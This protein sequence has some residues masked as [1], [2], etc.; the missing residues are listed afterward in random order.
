MVLQ[1][2]AKF[3][4]KTNMLPSISDP[5]WGKLVTGERE[6]RTSNIAINLLL[7]NS[8]LRYKKDPSPSNLNILILHTYD[9]F[10]KQEPILEDELK[11]IGSLKCAI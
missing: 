10:K 6:L 5:I 11:Q 8:K 3:D 4:K 9:V 2:H 1:K 7:Y